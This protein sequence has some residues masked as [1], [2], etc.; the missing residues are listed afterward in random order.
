MV[1]RV[2]PASRLFGIDVIVRPDEDEVFAGFCDPGG[3]VLQG[4]RHCYVKESCWP[5]FRAALTDKTTTPDTA[6]PGDH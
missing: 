2:T 5:A 1:E 3:Y 4:L 6:N